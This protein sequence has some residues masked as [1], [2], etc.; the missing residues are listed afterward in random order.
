MKIQKQRLTDIFL[1][2]IFANS[3]GKTPVLEF[4][5]KEVAGP[6]ACKF[7]R[8]R[9]QQKFFLVKLMKFLKAL[10]LQNTSGGCFLREVTLTI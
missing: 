3:T 10:F 2:K 8:K 9:L 1:V 4:L 6:Q 7:V 5:Y